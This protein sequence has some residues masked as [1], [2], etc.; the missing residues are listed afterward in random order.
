MYY[1]EMKQA[2][3]LLSNEWNLG[4]KECSAIGNSC[5]WIYLFTIL[6]ESEKIVSYKDGRKLVGFCGYSRNN[7]KKH[8]FKK[9]FYTIVKNKLYKSKNI[10]DL[11]ALK[12]YENNYEYLPKELENYFDGEVSI[13]LVDKN[14]RGKSIGKKLLFEVFDLAKKD[15]MKNLQILTDESCNF[16]FYENCG[17]KKIYEAIVKNQE[18]SKLG[19]I[20]SEKAFIYE[21]T[22][23]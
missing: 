11:N 9:K 22:L 16:K 3:E 1:S 20:S 13:L 6:E 10:K 12:Q 17:C 18:Y 19:N 21:K 23:I 2:V 8:L 14:Y 4:K 5:A 7:S 15:N